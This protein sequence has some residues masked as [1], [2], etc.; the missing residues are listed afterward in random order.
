[1][2]LPPEGMFGR[3]LCPARTG[4]EVI[5]AVAPEEGVLLVHGGLMA[6]LVVGGPVPEVVAVQ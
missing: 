5:L 1:M 6:A 4:I 2:P 3:L